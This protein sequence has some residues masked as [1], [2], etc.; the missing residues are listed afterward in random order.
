[1]D[2]PNFWKADLSVTTLQPSSELEER[3]EPLPVRGSLP[4][5]LY[6]G[7]VPIESTYHGSVLL[8]R[9]LEDYPRQLLTIFETGSESSALRRLP[10]VH[11]SS[12][13][14]GSRWL[15]TRFHSV[16]LSWLTFQMTRPDASLIARL[17]MREF[18]SVLT[19]SHGLGWLLA[20]AL[21]ERADVP[22]RLII[23]DDWPRVA[24]VPDQLRGWLDR[25][26]ARAYRQAASR[27]CVSPAMRRDY[28]ERYSCD[29]SVLYPSR[30]KHC[31]EFEEP[32]TQIAQTDHK[33]TIAFAGTVNSA[34]YVRALTTLRDSLAAVDGRLLIF[35]PLTCDD[36]RENGI[37][38]ERVELC[39]LVPAEELITRLREE[40]DALFIP[41]SFDP[42][43]RSNM[44]NAFPSKLTDCTA[45]GLP[46]LIYG[47]AY[48]SAVKWAREN[49]GSAEIVEAEGQSLLTEAIKRLVH[50]P[51]RLTL[52]ERALAVGKKYFAHGVAQEMFL[53]ALVTSNTEH[54]RVGR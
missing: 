9:L 38:H 48:C 28:L 24:N 1:M 39:G 22:L 11:Y 49:P 35:G 4:R 12:L 8:Y 41:M 16:V 31:P 30:S 19:V 45:A 36:A 3:P 34:G 2:Q 7:D 23:H 40:A 13:P 15:N 42:S 32:P 26:F 17:R 14:L 21:A 46:L 53:N 37:E 47:P 50:V 10:G 52:G 6:I 18:D 27:M 5:L 54:T 29:A 25:K 43:E 20:A 33:F 44:E 51:T